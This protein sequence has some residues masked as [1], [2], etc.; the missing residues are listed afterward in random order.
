M[1]RITSLSSFST[2]LARDSG[3]VLAA[4]SRPSSVKTPTSRAGVLSPSTTSAISSFSGLFLTR[5][6]CSSLRPACRSVD[7]KHCRVDRHHRYIFEEKEGK[8]LR[9]K[10]GPKK[11]V[12]ARLQVRCLL[13]TLLE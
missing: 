8:Q 13:L 7:I 11:V 6:T 5:L 9:Q 10:E 3:V 2:I 1:R 12:Q 4:C